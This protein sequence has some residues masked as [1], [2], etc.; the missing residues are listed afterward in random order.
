MYQA[1]VHITPTTNV[2]TTYHTY[3]P[4]PRALAHLR[5]HRPTSFAPI[6]RWVARIGI[7][8]VDTKLGFFANE[9]EAA[10]TYDVEA[11][12]LGRPTNFKE[13][14]EE[15]EADLKNPLSRFLGVSKS[16]G[17][18]LG[19]IRWVVSLICCF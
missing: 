9:R 17:A 13:A 12:R 16:Y 19:R 14:G 5:A 15:V 2:G 8:G 7:D 1:R 6:R 11:R 3:T 4:I 10:L 18:G